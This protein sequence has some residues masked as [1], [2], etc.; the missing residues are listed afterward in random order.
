MVFCRWAGRKLSMLGANNRGCEVLTTDKKKVWW[1]HGNN[2]RRRSTFLLKK[3]WA[4]WEDKAWS[5]RQEEA[6]AIQDEKVMSWKPKRSQLTWRCMGRLCNGPKT[7]LVDP[8]CLET[9]PGSQT[10][11]L[12]DVLS[13]LSPS[14]MLACLFAFD[15]KIKILALIDTMKL[16]LLFGLLATQYE[17]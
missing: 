12:F 11:V 8:T 1:T 16:L 7:G 10:V 3:A 2:G 4:I 6:L 17:R 13:F 5:C 9:F 15:Q 14:T